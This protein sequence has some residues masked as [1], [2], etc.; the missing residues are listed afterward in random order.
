MSV[1]GNVTLECDQ[2]ECY[3]E[4]Q[5]SPDRDDVERKSWGVVVELGASG[6]HVDDA[7]KTITCPQCCEEKGLRP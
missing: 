4:M 1:R 3:A 7:G 6:W 5:L 2:P